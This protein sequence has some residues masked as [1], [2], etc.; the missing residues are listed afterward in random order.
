MAYV[1]TPTFPYNDLHVYIYM[2]IY[3]HNTEAEKL[4]NCGVE[5]SA[6]ARPGEYV[7]TCFAERDVKACKASSVIKRDRSPYGQIAS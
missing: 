7:A 5:E 2:Y 3:R 6:D 4:T 1:Y